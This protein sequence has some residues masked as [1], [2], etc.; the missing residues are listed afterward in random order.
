MKIIEPTCPQLPHW[1]IG[2]QP[3]YLGH[4]HAEH[5]VMA[6]IGGL[7]WKMPVKPT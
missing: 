1:K 6:D 7:L 2:T 3:L 5:L 4:G